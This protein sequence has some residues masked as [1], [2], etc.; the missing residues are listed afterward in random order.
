MFSDSVWETFG[1]SCPIIV[2]FKRTEPNTTTE[3]YSVVLVSR[4]GLSLLPKLTGLKLSV[5]LKFYIYEG[6]KTGLK[7]QLL[8]I[9]QDMLRFKTH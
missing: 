7:I 9:T 4:D 8:S 1:E 6:F 3:I 5:T 2:R